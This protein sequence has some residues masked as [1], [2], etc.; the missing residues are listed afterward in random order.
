MD[1]PVSQVSQMSDDEYMLEVNNLKMHFAITRGIFARVKGYTKAADDVSFFIRKGETLGL[2]GESGCGKTTVGRCIARAYKPT[3]GEILFRKN[4]D[5]VVDL[6]QLQGKEVQPYRKD[7]RMIFQDPYS[8][9]NPRMTVFEIV[10]EAMKVNNLGYS[11][12]DERTG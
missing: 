3:A 10:S 5:T 8:S 4:N 7:I 1:K 2:V 6:A 11:C 9:L 12:P